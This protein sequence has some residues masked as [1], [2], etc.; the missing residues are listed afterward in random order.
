MVVNMARERGLT[1]QDVEDELGIFT[2]YKPTAIT[3]MKEYLL[4]VPKRSDAEL[5]ALKRP[6]GASR[7]RWLTVGDILVG[8]DT[9]QPPS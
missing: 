3:A 7:G 1:I 6:S 4:T 5:D 8:I 2:P 9:D